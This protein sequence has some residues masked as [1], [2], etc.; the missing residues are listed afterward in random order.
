MVRLAFERMTHGFDFGLCAKAAATGLLPPRARD[1]NPTSRLATTPVFCRAPRHRHASV[2]GT[3]SHPVELGRAYV[4]DTRQIVNAPRRATVAQTR[5]AAWVWLCVRSSRCKPPFSR[6]F[7]RPVSA[8]APT[9][10]LERAGR[11]DRRRAG[12][13][14]VRP[15]SDPGSLPVPEVEKGPLRSVFTT[16]HRNQLLPNCA[17]RCDSDA[18]C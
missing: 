18:D 2:L 13:A 17:G 14:P 11:V 9:V 1:L 16:W 10:W 3:A 5:V 12:S 4:A 8:K 15:H 7:F 6:R